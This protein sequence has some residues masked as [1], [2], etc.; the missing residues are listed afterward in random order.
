[1]SD[2]STD[3]NFR[4]RLIRTWAW[5]V[6]RPALLWALTGFLAGMILPRL[7]WWLL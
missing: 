7:V 4:T 5:F 2:D 1:M 6:A 3:L